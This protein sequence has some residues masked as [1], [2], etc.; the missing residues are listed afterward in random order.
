M[1]EADGSPKK[2]NY[3]R[4]MLKHNDQITTLDHMEE[5]LSHLA[6]QGWYYIDSAKDLNLLSPT[7]TRQ[8]TW[9]AHRLHLETIVDEPIF[10][11]VSQQLYH[12]RGTHVRG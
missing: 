1:E 10:R 3:I 6:L 9:S 11:P 4:Q 7:D 8:S 12:L 5:T 2:V